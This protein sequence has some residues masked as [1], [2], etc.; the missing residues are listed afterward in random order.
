MD[1]TESRRFP[2]TFSIG[3]ATFEKMP[4]GVEDLLSAADA[5]MYKAKKAGKNQI[6]SAVLNPSGE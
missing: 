3:V 4:Q 2:V 5:L 1:L 6:C